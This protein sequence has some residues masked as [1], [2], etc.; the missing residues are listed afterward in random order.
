MRAFEIDYPASV[1]MLKQAMEM[2]SLVYMYMYMHMYLY[3]YASVD[4]L[5]QAMEMRSLVYTYVYMHMHM[6]MQWRC[7]HSSHHACT[8]TQCMHS[9]TVHAFPHSACTQCMHPMH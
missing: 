3:M 4:M 9:H 6:C 1:D 5:K 7:A 8:P 2:R